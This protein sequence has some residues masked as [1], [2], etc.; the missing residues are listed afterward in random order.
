MQ[1][2]LAERLGVL[3]SA[4]DEEPLEWVVRLMEYHYQKG[5]QGIN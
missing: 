5:M 3:P 1:I 2:K 4:I